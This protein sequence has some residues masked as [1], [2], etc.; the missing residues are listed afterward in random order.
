MVCGRPVR[1]AA[2]AAQSHYDRCALCEH[3]CGANRRSGER[4][5]CKAG[6]EIRFFR[7]RI[8]Y[9]EEPEIVPSHLFY[10]TGC[11]LRCVF[12]IAEQF[13]F[14]PGRGAPLTDEVFREAVAWGISRGAR[15]LQWVGGEPTIH[16]PSI[17]RLMADC[18]A[19]PPVVWKSDFYGTPEAFALLDGVATTYVADFKFGNDSCAKRLSGAA[20]YLEIIG[21]NLRIAAH[22]GD[23]IVRHLLM[24][25]H[26]D[27][28]FRPVAEWVKTHLP[29]AKFSIRD[30]Y[31]PKWLA[32]HD[33]DLC[34][35][36]ALGVG[37]MARSQA[38]SLGLNLIF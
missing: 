13:A 14:D 4:G 17:L 37:E 9:G 30:G 20:N 2:A 34:R 31:L 15:N 7:H 27:C 11:D 8:E 12:C 28:C 35:P 19:L 38:Q 5:P 33:V 22:Q 25:G 3:R 10:L 6:D 16:L 29:H 26:Y 21:R 24:P 18:P 32:K 23:L 1:E 36:L